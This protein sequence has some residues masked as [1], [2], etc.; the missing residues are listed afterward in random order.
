MLY[1]LPYDPSVRNSDPLGVLDVEDAS[2][3]Q[4]LEA[5][6]NAA[7]DELN[8][9]HKDFKLASLIE[10][11]AYT[12]HG[13]GSLDTSTLSAFTAQQNSPVSDRALKNF[14]ISARDL[15]NQF[16]SHYFQTLEHDGDEIM[17][18]GSQINSLLAHQ[19]SGT[20]SMPQRTDWG[21][22]DLTAWYAGDPAH[23]HAVDGYLRTIFHHFENPYSETENITFS[24]HTA[25]DMADPAS[26]STIPKIYLKTVAEEFDPSDDTRET[27]V[28]VAAHSQP[29]PGA[30]GTQEER[31]QSMSPALGISA[32]VCPILPDTGAVVTLACLVHA[33]WT[34][35]NRTARLNKLFDPEMRPR[36]HYILADALPLDELEPSGK[37]S[38][39]ADLLPGKAER[40]IKKLYAAFSGPI[41]A[42][43]ALSTHEIKII[44][45]AGAWGCGAFGGNIL[46]KAV[47][48][49]IAVGMLGE[50]SATIFLTLLQEREEVD[51]IRSLITKG[52]T[53]AELWNT[54]TSV[55]TLSD[56][57]GVLDI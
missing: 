42:Q 8:H 49:M 38:S 39:L 51:V 15:P 1:Y 43:Q 44:I 25:E 24:L 45:E 27:H 13:D 46:V 26:C 52:Y 34:G 17:L 23:P 4:V 55:K 16:K 57:R 7:L 21:R 33:S 35:H 22:P 19:L 3:P 2:Q 56:L 54:V 31:L 47:C 53:T 32:L 10:D 14:L 28:L 41:K 20:L 29:G 37:D 30:T 36:R 5:L 9:D 48:I 40:E 11:I 50:V 18:S 6:Y 12:V